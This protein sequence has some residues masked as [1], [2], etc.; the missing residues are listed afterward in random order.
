MIL[1]YIVTGSIA[2]STQEKTDKQHGAII[3][4][5]RENRAS[6][7]PFTIPREPLNLATPPRKRACGAR[8]ALGSGAWNE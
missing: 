8:W 1:F 2:Y 3:L 4:I 7:H 6:Y 5:Y